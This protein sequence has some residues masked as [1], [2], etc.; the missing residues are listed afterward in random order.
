MIFAPALAKSA[1]MRST[2]PTIRCAAIGAVVH[3]RSASQ[4]GG[5]MV[6]LGT[7]WL[8]IVSKRI[9]SASGDGVGH[10][11]NQP[12]EVGREDARGSDG[13]RADTTLP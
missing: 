3:G 1:M 5:P 6:G 12:G 8:A 2:G 9:A 10:F 11:L 7:Q 13:F 4:T